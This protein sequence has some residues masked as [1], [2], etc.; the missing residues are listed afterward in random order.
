MI[1]EALLVLF[2]AVAPATVVSVAN[3][4]ATV[5]QTSDY[6]RGWEKG[7]ATGYCYQHYGCFPPLPPPC[8]MPQFM[9]DSYEDGYNDGFLKGRKDRDGQ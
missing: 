4:T 8:P 3:P 9:R 5:P 6:C 1:R 7:W 2:L